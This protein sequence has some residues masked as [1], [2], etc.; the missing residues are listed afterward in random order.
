MQDDPYHR[1]RSCES[2][3][4]HSRWSAASQEA[5]RQNARH[6][7]KRW[8][9]YFCRYCGLYHVGRRKMNWTDWQESVVGRKR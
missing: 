6:G 4:P 2:K 9:A 1:W 3:V 5:N 7:S 8:R